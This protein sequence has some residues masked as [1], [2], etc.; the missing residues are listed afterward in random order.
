MQHLTQTVIH[1]RFQ[2]V[3][4]SGSNL[5]VK[6]NYKISIETSAKDMKSQIR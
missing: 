2:P 6:L 5:D 4:Y 1:W 3:N